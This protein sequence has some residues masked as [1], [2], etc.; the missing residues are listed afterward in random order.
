MEPRLPYGFTGDSD[1]IF[2]NL[3]SSV[4]EK[5]VGGNLRVGHGSN[6]VGFTYYRSLYDKYLIPQPVETIIGG[7]PSYSG[8]DFY[9]EYVTNSSDSEIESMYESTDITS[10]FSSSWDKA[11]SS[12]EVMGVNFSASY[13]NIVFQEHVDSLEFILEIYLNS[14]YPSR[15]CKVTIPVYHPMKTSKEIGREI[16]PKNRMRCQREI[17]SIG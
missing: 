13:K 3:I 10:V 11:K 17:F 8:D 9:L 6:Y 4:N 1:I 14:I 7:D 2:D 16:G 12:R 15:F 5:T